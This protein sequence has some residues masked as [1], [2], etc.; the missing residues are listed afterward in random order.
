MRRQ[1]L[2]EVWAQ[3]VAL[4]DA[5]IKGVGVL[6]PSPAAGAVGHEMKAFEDMLDAIVCAWVGACVL[7][8]RAMAYGDETSAIWVPTSEIR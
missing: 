2:F 1:N 5:R 3:I 6:L 4:L 7:D 8:M